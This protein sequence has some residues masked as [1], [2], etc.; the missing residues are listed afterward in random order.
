ML[1][2]LN[3]LV[4]YANEVA[5]CKP[6]NLDVAAG[7]LIVLQ[8]PNGAG[9]STIMRAIAGVFK[10]TTGQIRLLGEIC[11]VGHEILLHESLSVMDNLMY[12][13]KL[14]GIKDAKSSVKQALSQL[15]LTTKMHYYPWQL[16]QGQQYKLNLAKL[17]FVKQPIWLL[18]EPLVHLDVA[19]QKFFIE[20]LEQHL[21]SGIVIITSHMPI[22]ISNAR[23]LICGI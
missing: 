9:K 11:Y 5:L 14:A 22:A 3:N 18:D 2:Q 7:Q 21:Q 23:T 16:S 17:L 10:N 8:G 6:I 20:I 1:M 4:C 15:K 12:M 13:F 19:S